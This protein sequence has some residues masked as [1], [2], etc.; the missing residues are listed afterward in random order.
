MEN[1]GNICKPMPVEK[2]RKRGKEEMGK[3][4]NRKC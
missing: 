3:L 1:M 4:K 2:I